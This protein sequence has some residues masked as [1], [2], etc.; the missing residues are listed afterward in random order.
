MWIRIFK[1][2]NL[3]E[4]YVLVFG[5]TIYHSNVA[6]LIWKSDGSK[7]WSVTEGAITS[8]KRHWSCLKLPGSSS[9]VIH[10]SVLFSLMSCMYGDTSAQRVC[11]HGAALGLF[12][13]LSCKP[14][15]GNS[16]AAP[17]HP[18]GPTRAPKLGKWHRF[19][20][21]LF[22]LLLSLLI[23]LLQAGGSGTGHVLRFLS[24]TNIKTS[25][26]GP[27]VHMTAGKDA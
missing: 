13:E 18:S 6:V 9:S 3:T 1:F 27:Q 8:F 17:T 26:L 10:T 11:L 25:Y 5:L 7:R 2:R 20:N 14:G 24:Y 23:P 22:P 4:Y 19:V 12:M 16:C 15:S 21:A